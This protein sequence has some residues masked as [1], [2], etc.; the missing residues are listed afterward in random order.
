MIGNLVM[1][2][3][4]SNW[5]KPNAKT[6]LSRYYTLTFH[7][8]HRELILG[9]YI[10]H[11]VKAGQAI[12]VRNRQRKL[13]TN[14]GSYWSN[15]VFEHPA[16][17]QTLAMDPRAKQDIIDDLLTFSK[18]EDFYARIGQAWRCGYLLYGPPG[19][20]KSTMIA[21]M[22][23]LLNY[24]IY[25][26]ELTAVRDN[27]ALRRLLIETTSKSI[28]VVEDIDC[29]LDLTEQRKKKRKART[30]RRRIARRRKGRRRG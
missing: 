13:Y 27:T 12:K 28:I 19:T 16:T 8:R 5:L 20:G 11:V 17:F 2:V 6:L 4:S 22:A 3:I 7:K 29:S 21:A 14:H 10:N 30:G 23:N 26:L 25:D 24:D 15:V 9:R 1:N 18:N